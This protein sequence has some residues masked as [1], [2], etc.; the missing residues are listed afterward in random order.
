MAKTQK[1]KRVNRNIA[2]TSKSPKGLG[3]YYG[4]GWRAKIGKMRDGM[5]FEVLS[6][7]KLKKPPKTLA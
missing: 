4:T 3:D 6:E 2:H 5:G 1:S 7:R